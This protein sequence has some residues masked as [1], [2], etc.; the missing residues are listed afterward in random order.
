[1]AYWHVSVLVKIFTRSLTWEKLV[2][3]IAID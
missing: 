1:L 2:Q 3:I